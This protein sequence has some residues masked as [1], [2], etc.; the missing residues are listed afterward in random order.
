[1]TS[2][3]TE[4]LVI[5]AYRNKV[6]DYLAKDVGF[7]KDLPS[8]LEQVME[9]ASLERASESRVREL[10][11]TNESLD[12]VNTE[13]QVQFDEL[14]NRRI[15]TRELL[16]GAVEDL[17]TVIA[18]TDDKELTRSLKKIQATLLEAAASSR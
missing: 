12:A 10:E 1:M 3:G 4:E 16:A 18:K 9:S 2:A 13:V 17:S 6:S 8:I 14:K 7:W 5:Q 11:R 15:A